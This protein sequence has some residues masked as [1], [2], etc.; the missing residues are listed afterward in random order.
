MPEHIVVAAIT[1]RPGCEDRLEAVLAGLVEP[2]RAEP[3]CLRYD[4]HRDVNAP[5]TFVFLEAWE[6][7]L[8][9]EN[10]KK[11]PHFLAARA[12]QEGLVAHREARILA[13]LA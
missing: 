2:S 11:T 9:H 10:H 13:H 12:E 8:A 3:G 5:A 4:L 7:P 1:A 6:S